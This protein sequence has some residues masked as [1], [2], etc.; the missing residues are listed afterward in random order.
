MGTDTR[1]GARIQ[2]RTALRLGVAATA[3]TVAASG[4]LPGL[5]ASRVLA[6]P[7]AQVEPGAGSWKTWVLASGSELR[8]PPPPDSASEL[9]EVRAQ[10]A[11]RDAQAVDRIEY[12]D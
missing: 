12:W 8:L 6:A 1:R 7:G 9:A 10:A 4:A 2:R 3:A 5:P 11:Q